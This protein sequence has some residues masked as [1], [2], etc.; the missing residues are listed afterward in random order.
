MHDVQGTA[1]ALKNMLNIMLF[2]EDPEQSF[3]EII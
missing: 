3:A 2:L 1:L